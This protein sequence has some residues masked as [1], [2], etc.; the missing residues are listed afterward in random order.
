MVRNDNEDEGHTMTPTPDSP[1][2]GTLEVNTESAGGTVIISASGEVDMVTAP[3]LED[4]ARRAIENA[5]TA[6]V[7][8]LGGV[9]F[10]SSAGLSVLVRT[11]KLAKESQDGTELRIVAT[12]PA[13]L[14]PIQ[15]MGLDDDLAIYATRDEAVT[16]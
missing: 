9:S 7:L 16:G 15:L 10:L 13:T 3:R 2:P 6:L 4:A 1:A 14:R 5:P 12:S 8:D 11:H